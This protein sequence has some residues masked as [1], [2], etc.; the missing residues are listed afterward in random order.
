MDEVSDW[1][2]G[3][4]DHMVADL[5]TFVSLETP[6]QE[7][8]L[9][10]VGFDWLNDWLVGS[11]GK[12]AEF[13]RHSDPEYGST[14]VSRYAG[15]GP[16]KV[17]LLSH[18]DTVWR[19]GTL[20]ERPFSVQD[21]IA[22]GPGIF[23]MKAGVVQGLWAVR[24]LD[25][26][27]I[28]RPDLVLV[29]NPDEEV[30]SVSSR[31]LIEDAC[32]DCDAVLVLE[33]SFGGALKTARKGV[34]IYEISA[35]GVAAHA[36]LDPERGASAITALMQRCLSA[37]DLADPA[38]G[39]TVSIGT[40]HGGSR[41]NVVAES[42]TAMVDTRAATVAEAERLDTGLRALAGAVGGATVSVTGGLNRP[43]ME[44]GPG[45]ARLY[46]LAT[47]AAAALDIALTEVSAGGGSDGNFAASM[48]LPVLDGLGP[49]GDG[50]HAEGEYIVIDKMVERARLLS[51]ILHAI[52]P[53]ITVAA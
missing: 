20:A 49:V 39:S 3:H 4:L 33:P 24:A 35:K 22:T 47:T 38:A 28:R 32:R 37:L 44:R 36:G 31:A 5:G 13:R 7:V 18:Y 1:L 2:S 23:D 25:R 15:E 52:P 19:S 12:P 46:G 8:P 40:F 51:G 41:T 53:S 45:T 26:L 34:G 6:S 21:G 10:D 42:A 27:G 30:G 14:L 17:A 48:G 50:A 43:V 11:L 16:G 9:L 29:F